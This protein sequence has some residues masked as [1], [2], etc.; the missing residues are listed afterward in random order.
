M[1]GKGRAQKTALTKKYRI[2]WGIFAEL[3]DVKLLHYTKI[4]LA[5]VIRAF[6]LNRLILKFLKIINYNIF[7]LS[8]IKI[9]Y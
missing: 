5:V 8:V 1:C 6:I 4:I 9:F 2:T 7:K 3:Y